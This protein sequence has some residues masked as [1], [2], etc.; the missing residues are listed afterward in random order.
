[1]PPSY[2]GVCWTSL[3]AVIQPCCS[4][5]PKGEYGRG[6]ISSLGGLTLLSPAPHVKVFCIVCV[7]FKRFFARCKKL[8]P[9]SFHFS[10]KVLNF[11]AL[12]LE[13]NGSLPPALELLDPEI[14]PSCTQRLALRPPG[15]DAIVQIQRWSIGPRNALHSAERHNVSVCSQ[16][17][18]PTLHSVSKGVEARVLNL[19]SS[20]LSVVRGTS[21]PPFPDAEQDVAFLRSVLL[22]GKHFSVWRHSFI[23]KIWQPRYCFPLRDLT[24]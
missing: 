6:L 13:Q 20:Q 5:R 1:L 17:E 14:Y 15:V 21:D 4:P 19:V 16:L 18:A 8:S 7:S 2:E 11:F 12:H 22:A 23:A 3:D 24:V 9:Y 10:S